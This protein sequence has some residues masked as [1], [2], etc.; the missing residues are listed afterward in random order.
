MKKILMICHLDGS[1]TSGQEAK[2]LDVIDQFRKRGF[3]VE[4]LNYGQLSLMNILIIF[5]KMIKKVD[6]VVLMP[7]GRK[8]L[9]FFCHLLSRYVRKKRIHYVVVGGWVSDYYIRN[10]KKKTFSILKRISGIYLQNEQAVSFFEQEGFNNCFYVSTFSNKRPLNEN[11]FNKSIDY[12]KSASLFKFCYFSRV[13]EDKGIFL[14]IDSIKEIKAKNENLNISLDVYGEFQNEY[15]KK[16]VFDLIKGFGC[17]N[18]CGVLAGNQVINTLSNYYCMLFPTFYPGEGTPHSVIES[19][20]A[21]LPVIASD[22]KYNRYLI[23]NNTEGIIFDL[24]NRSGLTDSI[25]KA[26]NDKNLILSMRYK[27]YE[28]SKHYTAD[29]VLSVLFNNL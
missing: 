11:D 12:F 18:Y 6:T 7:G 21:G 29:T 16:K 17:I 27:C 10:K 15:I 22:W 24:E 19:F 9:S 28:K 2:T 8:A 25:I 20:M 1:K 3:F 13:S 5:S 4:I 23:E 14:A 26:I